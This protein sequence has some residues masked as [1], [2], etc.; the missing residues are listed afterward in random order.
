MT[1]WRGRLRVETVLP[2][3]SLVVTLVAFV[4][5]AAAIG[6]SIS[7]YDGYNALQ[8]FAQL[9]LLALPL[10]LTMIA[11]EFD[12]S[13]AG[14]YALA[15]MLTVQFGQQQPLLGVGVAVVTGALVGAFQGGLIARFRLPS[16]PVTIA[17]YIIL[18]GVTSFISGGLTKTYTN[19]DATAFVDQPVLTLFSPRS[20]ITLALFV[21]IGLILSFS[22]LGS[23]L[24]AIGGD[25]RAARASGVRTDGLLVGL[26]TASGALAAVGGSLLSISYSSA[27]PDP[28]IQPLVLAVVAALIGGV[29]LA[30]GRGSAWGLLVGAVVV[31][32]LSQIVIFATLPGYVT[33]LVFA[34][35]LLIVIAVDAPGVRR[36]VAAYVDARQL[37]G[38]RE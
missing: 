24:R 14:V 20:L 13:V 36:R 27:N 29:S 12:L 5:A 19:A 3:V 2:G 7:P 30:G 18:L 8:G 34:G 37:R 21:A 17:S 15:G 38:T 31:A 28:G 10:G 9:G 25:R 1:R 6:R 4:V 23:E 22:R 32:L 35:F 16:M 11:G 26:F 33:Q